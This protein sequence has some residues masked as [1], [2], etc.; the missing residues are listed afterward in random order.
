MWVDFLANVA[1]TVIQVLKFN[2]FYTSDSLM[3]SL[4]NSVDRDTMLHY[5]A[6]YLGHHHFWFEPHQ[7]HCVVVF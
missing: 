1:D 6:F 2:P 4:A 3:V 7:R 5:A